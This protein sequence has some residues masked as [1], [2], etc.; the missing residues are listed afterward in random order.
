VC[1]VEQKP[2]PP[3]DRAVGLDMGITYLVADSNGV[4]TENPRAYKRSIERLAK[5]LRVVSR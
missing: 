2:L 3:S 5:A 4:T 1:A